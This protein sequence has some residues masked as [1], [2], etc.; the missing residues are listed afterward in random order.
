MLNKNWKHKKPIA[1]QTLL[2]DI[3]NL[4]SDD[5]VWTQEDLYLLE[6]KLLLAT[7]EPLCLDPSPAVLL[8]ANRQQYDRNKLNT[9]LLK[10][11]GCAI[12]NPGVHAVNKIMCF[13]RTNCCE[14]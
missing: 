2:C 14:N 11:W 12:G 5:H 3:N 1:A 13:F 6:G 9:P 7:E 10:R 8:L 4:T